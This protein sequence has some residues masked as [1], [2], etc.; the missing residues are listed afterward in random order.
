MYWCSCASRLTDRPGATRRHL[1]YFS[2][3]QKKFSTQSTVPLSSGLREQVLYACSGLSQ[4]FL[5]FEIK[6]LKQKS[7]SQ[8]CLVN[9]TD[10][11]PIVAIFLP[12]SL[13]PYIPCHIHEVRKKHK[14]TCVEN[15]V[16]WLGVLADGMH[17]PFNY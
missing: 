4:C 13:Q 3:V 16:C 6:D 14:I 9:E 15:L 2:S 10:P 12:T 1:Y 5:P 7:W 8:G 11:N 17:F